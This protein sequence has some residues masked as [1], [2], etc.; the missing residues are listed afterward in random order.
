V[1][2]QLFKKY[3]TYSW[4]AFRIATSIWMH[5]ISIPD[6]FRFVDSMFLIQNL[7]IKA[8]LKEHEMDTE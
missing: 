6:L 3:I 8:E 1:F 7:P 2:Q 5:Q 4:T